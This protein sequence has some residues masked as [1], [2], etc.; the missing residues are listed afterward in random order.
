[1]YMDDIK[2]FAKNEKELNTQIQALRIYIEDIG[3]GF[4]I[5]KCDMLIMSSG[6]QQNVGGRGKIRTLG[7]KETCKYLGILEVDNIKQTEMKE[8][9]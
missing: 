2:L 6:K 3:M 7:E 4:G 1:M 9:I 8:K 5:E